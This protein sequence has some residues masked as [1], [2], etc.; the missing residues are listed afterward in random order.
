MDEMFGMN[1]ILVRIRDDL[2]KAA[3]PLEWFGRWPE[4]ENQA[5]SLWWFELAVIPGLLQTED[6]MRAVLRAGDHQADVEEMV[7]AR[8]ERQRVLTKEDDPPML[9]SIISESVLRHN[10]GG[11]K[12]MA[13]QLAGLVEMA[14]GDNKIVIQIV[15]DRAPVC[16]G[17]LGGFIIATLDNGVDVAYLDNQL[18]GD[19]IEDV[20]SVRR[21]RHMFDS[22]RAEALPRMESI[23]LIMKE[24]ERWKH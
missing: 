4:V 24:M 5:T 18:A 23:S 12:T 13:D 10:V 22:F 1:G 16:A 2:V 19:V 11:A 20:E 7:S 21:L 15:P 17:F 14:E 9:S 3:V 8:L 6:Y